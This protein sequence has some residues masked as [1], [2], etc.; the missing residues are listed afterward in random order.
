MA[1]LPRPLERDVQ[2]AILDLLALRRAEVVRTNSGAM[3]VD[4]RLIRFNKTPG[5]SDVLVCY[6]GRFLALEVK[7]D[8]KEKPTDDQAAFLDRVTAAG[9]VGAVVWDVR[10]VAAILDSL[11]LE[12]DR[13]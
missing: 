12:I 10:D 11:D 2:A 3:K 7:R 13:G 4:G 6:R 9:G 5:C 1:R 8:Q